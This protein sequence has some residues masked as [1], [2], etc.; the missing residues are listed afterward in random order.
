M[1]A[2]KLAVVGIGCAVK[3]TRLMSTLVPLL[4]TVHCYIM[5]ENADVYPI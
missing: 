5:A 2:Q 1:F 4:L 3:Q